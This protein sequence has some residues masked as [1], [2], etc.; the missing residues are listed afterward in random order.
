MNQCF[1]EPNF[2]K[3]RVESIAVADGVATLT[4]PTETTIDSGN[5]VDIQLFTSI[6]AGTEGAE[7]VISN[8][9]AIASPIMNGDGNY[10]RLYPLTSRTVLRVQYLSDPEHFQILYIFPSRMRRY[11]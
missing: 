3:I 7:L 6:P 10:L 8:G 9:G 5:I 4:I 2:P 11:K 1:C